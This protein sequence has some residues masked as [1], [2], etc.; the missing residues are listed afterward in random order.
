[1]I[2][3]FSLVGNTETITV[4]YEISFLYPAKK[5]RKMAT[6]DIMEAVKGCQRNHPLPHWNAC[7]KDREFD[8]YL[9]MTIGTSPSPFVEDGQT[10]VETEPDTQNPHRCMDDRKQ[11]R[12]TL[13]IKPSSNNE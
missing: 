6:K 2:R 10:D 13:S 7:P 12:E 11:K 5:V 8:S 9:N 4:I 1:V 3:L